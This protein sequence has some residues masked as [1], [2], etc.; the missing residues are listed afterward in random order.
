MQTRCGWRLLSRY[1]NKTK[2]Q[3]STEEIYI[4]NDFQTWEIAIYFIYQMHIKHTC[5]SYVF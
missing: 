1:A 3:T 5:A 4:E 2:Q